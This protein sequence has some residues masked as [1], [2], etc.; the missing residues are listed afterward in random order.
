MRQ[1]TKSEIAHKNIIFMDKSFFHIFQIISSS[2]SSEDTRKK[3][4]ESRKTKRIKRK[5]VVSISKSL[6][7]APLR[8]RSRR[9]CWSSLK[10]EQTNKR[11]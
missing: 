6:F 3:C 2:F 7:V 5:I 8:R 11:N 9:R 10:Y 1:K 4:K